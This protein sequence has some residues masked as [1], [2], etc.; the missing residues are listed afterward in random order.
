MRFLQFTIW[1]NNNAHHT[2]HLIAAAFDIIITLARIIFQ[3]VSV[4]LYHGTYVKLF[5][6]GANC[7]IRVPIENIK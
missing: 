5:L 2:L 7:F 4:I 3:S 6:R 1:P